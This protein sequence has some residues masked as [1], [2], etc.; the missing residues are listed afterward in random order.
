M[1]NVSTSCSLTGQRTRA[2]GSCIRGVRRR[3]VMSLIR[4]LFFIGR[5][6]VGGHAIIR[7]PMTRRSTAWLHLTLILTV[8]VAAPST[9]TTRPI[10]PRPTRLRDNRTFI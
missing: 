4:D 1:V 9:V 5:L 10:S 8:L 3:V 6:L 7:P 2:A